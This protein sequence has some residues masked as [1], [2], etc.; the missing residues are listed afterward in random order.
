MNHCRFPLCVVTLLALA[1][2]A[3]TL[4]AQSLEVPL[5][6]QT[7]AE[8]AGLKRAWFAQVPLDQARSKITSVTLQSGA[9]LVV[10][11]EI[12]GRIWIVDSF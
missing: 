4:S 1:I 2:T 8:H 5:V 7:V 10:T 11:N 9:L 12:R 3:K 6:P